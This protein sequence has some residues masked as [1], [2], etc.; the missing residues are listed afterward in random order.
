MKELEKYRE[1]I[2]NLRD[3]KIY[4]MDL[5]IWD[6]ID[7]QLDFNVRNYTDDEILTL[8]DTVERAYMKAENIDLYCVVKCCI[9]NIDN[10][11]NMSVWDILDEVIHY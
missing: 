6:E 2:K 10:I 7:S 1:I 11:S 8:Y 9:D 5:I 4:L 3:N